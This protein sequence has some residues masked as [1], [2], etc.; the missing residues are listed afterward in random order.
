[1]QCRFHFVD[2]CMAVVAN[3]AAI[4]RHKLRTIDKKQRR[5]KLQA[6]LVN[7]KARDF[8]AA[9]TAFV[10]LVNS[11]PSLSSDSELEKLGAAL[12]GNNLDAAHHFGL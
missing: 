3:K 7:L 6:L 8:D 2:D 4:T 9:C 11:G 1:M 10:A 12:N 5:Q